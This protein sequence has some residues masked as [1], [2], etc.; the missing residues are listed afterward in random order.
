MPATVKAGGD[1]TWTLHWQAAAPQPV[2]YTV[3]VHLL[4][5]Q[6]EKAAQLDW[7]PHDTAGL[8]PA[9]AWP[10]GRPVVDTQTLALPAD[11]SPGSYR[12]V[13][14]LYDWRDGAR[15]PVQGAGALSGDM[16]DL[17]SVRVE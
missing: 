11:L 10:V 8:L 12:L 1:L 4:D 16:L 7:Q 14:G 15:L 6:G 13:V 17:G 2:D 5:E 3:F 9:T